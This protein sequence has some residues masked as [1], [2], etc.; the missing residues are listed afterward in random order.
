MT[1]PNHSSK[2]TPILDNSNIPSAAADSGI[3]IDGKVLWINRDNTCQ[4]VSADV[5]EAKLASG[6]GGIVACSSDDA[7]RVVARAEAHSA[8]RRQARKYTD[9]LMDRLRAG[10]KGA[11]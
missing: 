11:R 1:I 4:L 2:H 3:Q 9:R 7:D 5:L 10:R 6:V 8:A